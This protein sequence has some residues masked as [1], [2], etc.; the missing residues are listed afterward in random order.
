M[1]SFPTCY[2]V[3]DCLPFVEHGRTVSVVFHLFILCHLHYFHL[4]CSYLILG[5]YPQVFSYTSQKSHYVGTNA[6]IFYVCLYLH[7]HMLLHVLWKNCFAFLLKSRLLTSSLCVFLRMVYVALLWLN[8]G[9]VIS[10]DTLIL[11]HFSI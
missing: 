8:D 9:L 4:F 5:F 11:E 10:D 3:S 7:L 2:V 6:I 1:D